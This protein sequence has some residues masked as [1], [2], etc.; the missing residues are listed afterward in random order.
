MQVPGRFPALLRPSQPHAG[1]DE[2]PH[3][4]HALCLPAR[5]STL[6]RVDGADLFSAA[7]VAPVIRANAVDRDFDA[8]DQKLVD[9]R[10]DK[11]P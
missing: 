3:G 5:G 1:H 8:A 10:K 2:V 4:N 9:Q 7:V 11:D 6:M